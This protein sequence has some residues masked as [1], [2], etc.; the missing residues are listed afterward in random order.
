MRSADI[1]DVDVADAVVVVAAVPAAHTVPAI[2]Y[3]AVSIPPAVRANEPAAAVT[4]VALTAR[5]A[6]S[7]S[8]NRRT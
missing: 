2:V 6:T 7:M 3:A 1:V 5:A 8:E 4:S